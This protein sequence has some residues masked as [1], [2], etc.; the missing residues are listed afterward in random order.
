MNRTRILFALVLPLVCF[1]AE[2]NAVGSVGGTVGGGVYTSGTLYANLGSVSASFELSVGDDTDC[3]L[4]LSWTDGSGHAQSVDVAAD[5]STIVS[6]SLKPTGAL[7]WT[8]S[9]GVN[10][11]WQ[12]ERA[13]AQSV[14][15]TVSGFLACGS[16]GTPYNNLRGSPVNLDFEVGNTSLSPCA[17]TISWTD[18]SGHARTASIDAGASEGFTTALQAGGT[19]SWTAAAGTGNVGLTWQLERV[20]NSDLW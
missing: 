8:Q 10:F 1:V 7:S 5:V 4:S 9:C 3:T 20:V 6:S 18:T 13:P 12:L 2:P 16:S 11:N 14:S 15:N 19:I 17:A